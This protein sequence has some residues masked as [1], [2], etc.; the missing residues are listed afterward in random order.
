MMFSMCTLV[1]HLLNKKA[2]T[3]TI[4]TIYVQINKQNGWPSGRKYN[5]ASSWEN[6][7]YMACALCE[8]SDQP[9]HLP[10]QIRDFPIRMKKAWVLSYPLSTQRRLWSDWADA[11]ADLSLRWVRSHFVGFV[12]RLLISEKNRNCKTPK[13]SDTWKIAVIILKFEQWCRRNDKQC[14]PWPDYIY[15]W[16]GSALFAQGYMSENLRSL[17]Y[18]QWTNYIYK[19]FQNIVCNWRAIVCYS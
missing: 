12:I 3:I 5:W 7:Q 2:P 1:K 17:W 14:R 8:D 19:S 6:Q 18:A 16:S 15:S 11:Q 13:Y 4:F 9:G 10:S